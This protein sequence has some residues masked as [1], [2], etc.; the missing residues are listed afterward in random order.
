MN[1]LSQPLSKYNEHL[2]SHLLNGVFSA[3]HKLRSTL[4]QTIHAS[5]LWCVALSGNS[6]CQYCT[7][8]V[9]L[10]E[11][12]VHIQETFSTLV[13]SKRQQ[14]RPKTHTYETM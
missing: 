4:A 3:A 12:S 14:N 1:A 9:S 8:A 2:L 5:R 10:A 13:S 11:E 6:L 7:Y